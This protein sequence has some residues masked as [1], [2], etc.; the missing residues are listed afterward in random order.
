M[1][2]HA[3]VRRIH[4]FGSR[5]KAFKE[6]KVLQENIILALEKDGLKNGVV[7]STSTDDT[8]SDTSISDYQFRE[9]VRL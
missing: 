4:L 7:V 8:F 3:A 2:K 5:N 1:L 9:I 6:D